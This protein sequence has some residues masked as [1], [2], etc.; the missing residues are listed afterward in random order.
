MHRR[1]TLY[2][3]SIF[4][5][6]A[7]FQVMGL[8]KLLVIDDSMWDRYSNA[9]ISS[10]AALLVFTLGLYG[11]WRFLRSRPRSPFAIS[12]GESLGTIATTA[13][14]A[15][16]TWVAP[17]VINVLAVVVTIL[18]MLVIRAAVVPSSARRTLVVGAFSTLWCVVAAFWW[19]SEHPPNDLFERYLWTFGLLWGTLFTISTAWISRVIYGLQRSVRE[20]LQL[21]S[22]TLEQKLGEG[23][24]G[25]VY[26]ARH[27]LLRRP[28]AVKLLPTDKAGD[29]DV[30]RF[31]REVQ[32]T[33]A[34]THPNIVEIYDFGRT[35]DGVF[36]YA[37]EYLDGPDLFDLVKKHGPL[38]AGRVIYILAQAA[39]ALAHAHDRGLV[40]RDVKPANLVLCDRGGIADTVKVLDFGLVKTI[41]QQDTQLTGATAIAGTPLFLAPES[42]EDPAEVD[43]RADLYSLG[44]VGYYLLTGHNVFEG[45]NA[46]AL[47]SAHVHETPI[48][49]NKRMD[50]SV[51]AD[52]LE[53]ILLRCLAKSPAERFPD[54]RALQQALSS[55]A[56]ASGWNLDQA[57]AWW[58][59]HREAMD[60]DT[61]AKSSPMAHAKT[62]AI[63]LKER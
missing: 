24:M 34:L 36:Y 50:K 55:C 35:S 56:D 59:E 22:Y 29:E 5:L 37:M 38:P 58:H 40:H 48:P 27:A 17:H 9:S 1:V 20:A 26:K 18:L 30:L 11:D 3:K 31:E 10:M 44:A 45:K 6:F 33:S 4:I 60:A 47:C 39:H 21:G 46:L 32:E 23:G 52:D 49:P 12:V 42:I 54:G 41:K 28:T 51:C 15:A 16:L 61:K 14:I 63:N 25:I 8:I 62:V 43:G 13:F 57:C 7:S 2:V 53:Q 19:L